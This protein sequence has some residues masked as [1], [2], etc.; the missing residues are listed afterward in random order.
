MN[1]EEALA[2]W[3]PAGSPWSPWTKGVL[4]SFMPEQI[5]D[6]SPR[7][8]PAWKVPLRGDTAI[9]I[10]LAG[11][12]AI[13][14]GIALAHSG[15]RPVPLYNACPFGLAPSYTGGV[16]SLTG[17]PSL[18]AIG[19]ASV[20]DVVPIMRALANETNTLREIC[21]PLSAPPAFML[22]ANRQS[23][24]SSP[25]VGAFDNRSVIRESD[26]PSAAFLL[27]RGI[28]QVVVVRGDQSLKTDLQAVLLSW[29]T[30]GLVITRQAPGQPWDP[31]KHEVS[32]IPFLKSWWTKFM[33][34]FGYRLN[35]SGS[36]GSFVHGSSG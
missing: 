20:V 17:G 10:E 33:Q 8:I 23:G 12:R 7:H 19:E 3:A 24:G 30:A 27:D 36:F 25:H 9:F 26:V 22:D 28:R 15:Y 35:T 21:L 1:R 13:E 32:E 18:M 14:V 2:V 29:Q 34:H 16:P 11:A 6:H 5:A 4:F 31:V